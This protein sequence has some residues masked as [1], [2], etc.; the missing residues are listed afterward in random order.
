MSIAAE[1]SYVF[2]QKTTQTTTKRDGLQ[3][4]NSPS[5]KFCVSSERQ[6]CFAWR[7]NRIQRPWN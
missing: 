3:L 6:D 4:I 2:F 1:L 7:R 5:K